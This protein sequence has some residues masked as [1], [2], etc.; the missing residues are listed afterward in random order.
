[1]KALQIVFSIIT[2]VTISACAA[3]GQPQPETMTQSNL[4]PTPDL[5]AEFGKFLADNQK[6]IIDS[7]ESTCKSTYPW[8]S[9]Q[10]VGVVGFTG[11]V[12]NVNPSMVTAYLTMEIK[13]D[14][15]PEYSVLFNSPDVVTVLY[16]NQAIND[17]QTVQ[18][19][20]AEIMTKTNSKTSLEGRFTIKKEDGQITAYDVFCE[21]N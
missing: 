3:K 8:L 19:V 16:N 14:I 18:V 20:F 1:M 9:G 2:V 10:K 21:A 7:L 13:S 4:A 12:S 17:Q 6:N 11:I 15:Y 5:N